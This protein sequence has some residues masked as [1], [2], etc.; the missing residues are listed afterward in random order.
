MESR[1]K[2]LLFISGFLG[3]G[4][5]TFLKEFIK[6][7]RD[8][9]LNIIVNE[10]G[11][12]GIDGSIVEE[13]AVEVNEISNGSVLCSC[14]IDKFIE[15]LKNAINSECDLIIVE[16]SGFT[17]P[18]NLKNVI[19]NLELQERVAFLGEVCI[20]DARRFLKLYNTAVIIRKQIKSANVVLVN[21]CDIATEEAINEIK[22]CIYSNNIDARVYEGNYGKFGNI[23]FQRSLF[24]DEI[25]GC[26]DILQT[27]DLTLKK[28][29]IKVNNIEKLSNVE[30][31]VKSFIQ[32]TDRVK[33]FIK[34]EQ[35]TYYIDC[36]G[37]VYKCDKYNGKVNKELLNTIVILGGHGLK[38]R[39]R[40]KEAL[41]EYNFAELE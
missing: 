2:E 27:A 6:N 34:Y 4:K 17:D 30:S 11:K 20:V 9:K 10:F 13:L 3:A 37:E 40:V 29:S 33:G 14:K 21:K 25:Q 12:A 28:C 19:S 5:T 24:T 26:K 39:T 36:V 16:A 8:K 15:T 41:K 7:N 38:T 23:N 18:S 22:S 32:E 35:D 31:L 1:L